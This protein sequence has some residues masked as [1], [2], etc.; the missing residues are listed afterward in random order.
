M[1]KKW[2]AAR[3]AE[4][5]PAA[6]Y[7]EIW[8]LS[9]AYRPNDFI[10]NF[11]Y[12]VTFPHFLL[13]ELDALP[14][15]NEGKGKIFT[16]PLKRSD[17]TSWKMQL[18]WH[19]GS[20]HEETRK[21]VESINRLHAVH[22]KKYPASFDRTAPYIYTLCYEAAGMHRLLRRVGLPGLSENEKLA[23]I[24]YWTQMTTLFRNATTGE[25]LSVEEFPQTWEAIDAFMDEYES[26]ELPHN[27]MGRQSAEAVIQQ[28][29]DRYFPRPLHPAVRAWI[30]SL[31]PDHMLRTYGLTRPPAP[32]V[33]FYRI[34]T[35]AMLASGEKIARDP[36]DTFQERRMAG[37]EAGRPAQAVVTAGAA[38]GAAVDPPAGFA[39]PGGTAG[40]AASRCPYSAN[41]N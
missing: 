15:Y 27:D 6:D 21:N 13:R 2:I 24:P 36:T 17:D 34:L 1:P 37:R 33:R 20:H 23:A 10:M 40:P 31:Y 26:E 38:A 9:T 35:A 30:L 39:A 41:K 32:V 12:A 4:L 3:I 7:D 8:K 16:N 19:Y 11:I 22:A 14:V 28:F 5:D 25:T 18:W 29:A